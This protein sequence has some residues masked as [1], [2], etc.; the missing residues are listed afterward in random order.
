MTANERA[1][2]PVRIMFKPWSAIAGIAGGMLAGTVFKQI[3]RLARGEDEA[4][5]AT[6]PARSWT[7]TALAAALEGAIFGGVKALVDR[8]AATGFAKATGTWPA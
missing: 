7:E 5:G 4:P 2:A 1:S 8:G 3:W 6:D